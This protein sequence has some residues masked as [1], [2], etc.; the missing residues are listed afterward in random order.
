MKPKIIITIEGGRVQVIQS[1]MDINVTILDADT[2][3][4]NEESLTNIDGVDYIISHD[5][6]TVIKEC[7][8]LLK[9]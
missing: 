7:N 2:D 9:L 4:V 8:P 6:P 3:G 1:N 5:T